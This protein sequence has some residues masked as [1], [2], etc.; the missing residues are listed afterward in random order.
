MGNCF[1]CCRN[2][3]DILPHNDNRNLSRSGTETETRTSRHNFEEY[4]KNQ[5]NARETRNIATQFEAPTSKESNQNNLI[6]F[7]T[8]IRDIQAATNKSKSLAPI[9]RPD[10]LGPNNKQVDASTSRST[11]YYQYE[12]QI[13]RTPSEISN[14]E[15]TS[16]L[17]PDALKRELH[18]LQTNKTIINRIEDILLDLWPVMD[19]RHQP[20]LPDNRAYILEELDAKS[21]RFLRMHLFRNKRFNEQFVIT[22]AVRV[23]NPYLMLQYALNKKKYETLLH[24]RHLYHG[25]RESSIHGI[26]THNFDWRRV[27]EDT[28]GRGVYFANNPLFASHFSIKHKPPFKMIVAKVLIDKDEND[29]RMG[30]PG[31]VLPPIGHTALSKNNQEYIKFEDGCFYP[32]FLVSFTRIMN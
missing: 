13:S 3:E 25:T 31:M 10:A 1:G 16:K 27:Q 18:R 24:E 30:I 26:L 28:F 15:T 7:E 4:G 23:W 2:N 17:M 29:I 19:I 20:R 11:H 12:K 21:E 14:R 8:D 22:R 6:S 5:R 32:E 9:S